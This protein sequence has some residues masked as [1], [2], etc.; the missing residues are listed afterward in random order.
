MLLGGTV[1]IRIWFGLR[2]LLMSAQGCVPSGTTRA[3]K[4]DV[5]YS[6]TL[7]VTGRWVVFFVCTHAVSRMPGSVNVGGTPQSRCTACTAR[8]QDRPPD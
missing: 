8:G 6:Q 2:A 4:Q 3:H 7:P 5:L 1:S